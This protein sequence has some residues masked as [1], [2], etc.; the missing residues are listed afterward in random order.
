MGA[1]VGVLIADGLA[2]VDPLFS[3]GTDALALVLESGVVA[4]L[5]CAAG[6]QPASV[7]VKIAAVEM[8]A[9]LLVILISLRFLGSLPIPPRV[10]RDDAVATENQPLRR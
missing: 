10:Y 4:A 5:F 8:R 2:L 1:A 6:A 9:T 3:E 7:K